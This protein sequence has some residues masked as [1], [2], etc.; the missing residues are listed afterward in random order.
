VAQ[1]SESVFAAGDGL[2]PYRRLLAASAQ[3]LTDEG[4]LILQ[5]HRLAVSAGEPNA[6]DRSDPKG[7]I[8]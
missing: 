2:E 5:F 6:R 8:I 3:R 1:P 4:A 7:L